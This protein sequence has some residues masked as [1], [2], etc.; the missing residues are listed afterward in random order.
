MPSL[1]QDSRR[2]IADVE[3]KLRSKAAELDGRITTNEQDIIFIRRK[4]SKVETKAKD[5]V[6]NLKKRTDDRIGDLR[7]RATDLETRSLGLS[8]ELSSAQKKLDAI[9]EVLSDYNIDVKDVK[10]LS[11]QTKNQLDRFW[12]LISAVLVF[13]MQA[14]FKTLEAGLVRAEHRASVG[15][16]NLL[17]WLVVSVA[18]YVLGFGFMYGASD[19]GF[20]GMSMFLPSPETMPKELKMEF[21]LFQLA[22][23]GTA[24]TIVSGA[25]AERAALPSYLVSSVV[26]STLVY[27]LF[28]HWVWGNLYLD[29]NQ[30]WLANL[31]FHD[32]AGGTVVHA[33]GGWTALVGVWMILP[34][35]GRFD[36]SVDQERA[37]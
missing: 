1:A 13:L 14:G 31:G 5:R 12:I 16:K 36:P 10:G 6:Q 28:G 22:F 27:P 32:F 34:R 26:I 33:V 7:S 9:Q 18:F 25:L 30:P 4:V 24:A 15:I 20:F 11:G 8:D 29:T 3:N 23:A 2:A 19:N 17:D 37:F 21:F 35:R